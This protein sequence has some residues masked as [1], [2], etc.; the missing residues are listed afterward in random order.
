MKRI[1]II[2]LAFILLLCGCQ[3]ALSG[4]SSKAGEG[5]LSETA[6][7]P[8][9]SGQY[10]ESQTDTSDT[11]EPE[12]SGNEPNEDDE[13]YLVIGGVAVDEENAQ[14]VFGDGKVR[15]EFDPEGYD[16]SVY[17]KNADIKA[18]LDPNS[19]E[20]EALYGIY[21]N[22]SLFIYLDGNNSIAIDIPDID[23]VH[24]FGIRTD[25][26]AAIQINGNGSLNIHTNGNGT[27]CEI[28]GIETM[29]LSVHCKSLDIDIKGNSEVVGIYSSRG[30]T[31]GHH[32]LLPKITVNAESASK[33]ET[34]FG[35]FTSEI[36]VSHGAVDI[37]G[38]SS[39]PEQVY[40]GVSNSSYK[41]AFYEAPKIHADHG[42]EV[43]LRG[44]A[45]VCYGNYFYVDEM[46]FSGEDEFYY[47]TQQ[48][49][50]SD[51]SDGK[52]AYTAEIIHD[53]CPEAFEKPYI[54][55]TEGPKDDYG[56]WVCG[57]RITADNAQDVFGDGTVK[58]DFQSSTLTLDN[59][60]LSGGG[61]V[62]N[63]FSNNETVIFAADSLN[64]VLLGNSKL[65]CTSGKAS[66]SCA[67]SVDGILRISGDGSVD[68][69]SGTVS[70]IY[71]TSAAIHCNAYCQDGGKVAA[72][73]AS[74]SENSAEA[75]S[76][77]M[78]MNWDYF[79]F[80]GGELYAECADSKYSYPLHQKG[81]ELNFERYE[82]AT[83]E[84]GTT[85]NGKFIKIKEL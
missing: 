60:L 69:R 68:L 15:V 26:N 59:A 36:D 17:L 49:L 35:I 45:S 72:I 33:D 16:I 29:Q 7:S 12:E 38:F 9:E 74:A 30:V 54:K 70:G 32:D 52:N 63:H 81:A 19:S 21:S 11:S 23:W 5:E 22:K 56:V 46:F 55:I 34:V 2:L 48:I 27:A 57:K 50:V 13:P 66:Y 41:I 65:S 39:A 77:G 47:I 1:A 6:S 40:T 79:Y 18:I 75:G 24:C 8:A 31:A 20:P 80:H 85:E 64:V 53:E 25:S 62:D 58:Y 71:S 67:L 43:I 14:D 42:G 84:S 82:N 51:N 78:I 4:E 61:F 83:V 3:G 76:Y 44:N 28:V 10:S 73:G 37:R